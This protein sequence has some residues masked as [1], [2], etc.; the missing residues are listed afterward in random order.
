MKLYYIPGACSLAPHIAL[1]EAGIP[2]TYHLV[3]KTEDGNKVDGN[4]YREINPSGLV[5][6]LVTDDG[7]RIAEAAVVLQFIASQ[8]EGGRLGDVTAE[9]RWELQEILNFLA[10]EVHKSYG[11][12]F[13]PGLPADM[14]PV[15]EAQ[16][17]DKLALA[18]D[19][20]GPSGYLVGD[21][22]TVADAYL[23][24]LT[25][26]AVHLQIDLSSLPK[27][28]EYVGRIASRPA[29]RQALRD[30]GLA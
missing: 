3:E 22:F 23:F 20:I 8:V 13:H 7:R 12:L 26:W 30:E 9:G 4:D 21:G 24:T 19:R 14:R 28:G 25:G 11:P 1:L 10:T 2:A 27:L 29:V 15:V 17:R 16:V 5:P 6:A 18:Q